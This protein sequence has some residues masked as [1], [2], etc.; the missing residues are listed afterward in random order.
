[1][2]TGRWRCSTSI[3]SFFI[4]LSGTRH[5]HGICKRV[6][7]AGFSVSVNWHKFGPWQNIFLFCST[8]SEKKTKINITTHISGVQYKKIK[9]NM[10]YNGILVV[11]VKVKSVSVSLF[12]SAMF[13]RCC[14]LNKTFI[15]EPCV[16]FLSYIL[17][18]SYKIFV[19]YRDIHNM[20]NCMHKTITYRHCFPSTTA[21]FTNNQ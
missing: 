21:K 9:I 8:T 6:L 2:L 11:A 15:L 14:D 5:L 7:Q 12:T 4:F 3:F 18:Y 10:Q 16:I 13:W 19:S 1:M 20:W 17:W